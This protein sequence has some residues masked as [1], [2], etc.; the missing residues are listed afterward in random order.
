[1]HDSFANALIDLRE[2]R[3]WSAAELATRL[4]LTP[5]AIWQWEKGQT[6]PRRAVVNQL[7][8]LFDLNP[9]ELAQLVDADRITKRRETSQDKSKRN[10]EPKQDSAPRPK[11]SKI[12]LDQHDDGEVD[13]LIFMSSNDAVRYLAKMQAN[14][15]RIAELHLASRTLLDESLNDPNAPDIAMKLA[16]G[17]EYLIEIKRLTDETERYRQKISD[18]RSKALRLIQR[19]RYVV[20][21]DNDSD[22]IAPEKVADVVKRRLTRN[23]SRRRVETMT[24]Y[25]RLEEQSNRWFT[26]DA[27]PQDVVPLL[28]LLLD[29]ANRVNQLEDTV[30]VLRVSLETERMK[31]KGKPAIGFAEQNF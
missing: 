7:E 22:E 27:S 20:G 21:D 6:F 23:S 13:D 16:T 30:N 28:T 10:S 12:T 5:A 26:P 31:Q 25:K 14:A 8:A 29:L 15:A 11:L 3:G 18:E 17:Q 1:M 24:N 19:T 4:D 9:T 2:Q